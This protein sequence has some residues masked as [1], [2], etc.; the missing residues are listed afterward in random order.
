MIYT[1]I[2]SRETPVGVLK[3]MQHIGSYLAKCG[4]TLRSGAAGGADSAFERGCDS[5]NGKK[6]IYLPWNGF[7]KRRLND[8]TVFLGAN[9]LSMQVAPQ[10]HPAWERCSRGA[11]SLHARNVCQ[12]LGLT[13]YTLTDVVICWTPRGSGSGGTGQ[14]IRMARSLKIPVIDLGHPNGEEDL[15][16]FFSALRNNHKF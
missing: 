5:S 14:A 2:G 1:G 6:E 13:M 16:T 4:W 8:E 15:Y 11:R 7:N 9:D 3:D 12:I 10:F